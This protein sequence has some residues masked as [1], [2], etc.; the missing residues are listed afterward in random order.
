MV[1][2]DFEKIN[3]LEK[4]CGIFYSKKDFMFSMFIKNHSA[5]LPSFFIS[6]KVI[7]VDGK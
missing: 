4:N 2:L 7:D 6:F 1:N 3:E 5:L